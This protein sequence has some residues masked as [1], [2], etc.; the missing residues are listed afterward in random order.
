MIRVALVLWFYCSSVHAMEWNKLYGEL[1]QFDVVR[2]GENV[3]DYRVSFQKQGDEWH[4]TS[5]MNMSISVFLLFTYR[6]QYRAEEVWQGERLK[7]LSVSESRN[8]KKM[9]LSVKADNHYLLGEGQSGP[10]R[11][12]LPILTTSHY[13]SAVLSGDQVLNTLTGEINRYTLSPQQQEQIMTNK[14]MKNVHRFLYEGELDKTEVWYTPE[15]HWV[16]LWF[17]GD[18]GSDIEFLCKRCIK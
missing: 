17:K 13:N 2:N 15:G 12:K 6:Y 14:G 10:I 7:K 8:G 18:D 4:I 16:K 5:E 1:M 3:G 11:I 9:S